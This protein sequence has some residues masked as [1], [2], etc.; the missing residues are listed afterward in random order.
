MSADVVRWRAMTAT[1]PRSEKREDAHGLLLQRH[2][3][4]RVRE[5]LRCVESWRRTC[6]VRVEG[7]E[8]RVGDENFDGEKKGQRYPASEER[9]VRR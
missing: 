3:Q 8:R 5:G 6:R 7:D 1:E 2:G 9:H 4:A